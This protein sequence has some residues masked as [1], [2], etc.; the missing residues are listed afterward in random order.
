[1]R[2]ISLPLRL[3]PLL[4][5]LLLNLL[6][7]ILLLSTATYISAENQLQRIS[8]EYYGDIGCSH[9]DV[10]DTKILPAAEEVSGI[11]AEVDYINVLSKSGF[12]QCEK[13]L[14]EMGFRYTISPVMIIGNNVYQGNSAVEQGVL[15]ELLYAAEYGEYL[16]KR[17]ASAQKDEPEGLNLA[18]LPVFLAGLVDGVNPCAFATMLFFISWIALRGGSGKRMILAGIGFIVGV[19][20]AYFI[21]G[22]GLFTV[23]QAAGNLTILRQVIRYLFSASAFILALLSMRDAYLIKK[24]G[25]AGS[26]LLQLPSGI[27]KRI[28]TV[29]RK[30]QEKENSGRSWLL[31]PALLITGILVALL[32]LACTGQIYFPTI[33]YMVQSGYDAGAFFWLILY[34]AAFIFPLVLLFGLA[35]AGVSQK[36]ITHWFNRNVFGGKI[37]AAVLFLLLTVV[38][39]VS[40]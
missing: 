15:E 3:S 28:H 16:P 24:T 19:F 38:I 6:L 31:F 21:I 14:A 4:N 7:P 23:F 17:E 10:F 36:N 20:I 5:L 27:K 37:A 35:L 22:L 1:M 26:M 29:I 11:T 33:A 30:N 2:K 40:G 18:V 12:E 13:R 39:W 34:N 32:E 9:C 25:N 8:I